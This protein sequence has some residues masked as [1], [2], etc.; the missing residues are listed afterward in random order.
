MST[1]FANDPDFSDISPK[2]RS[3]R[4]FRLIKPLFALGAFS[5][6]IALFL[7]AS[8]SSRPAGY[9][10]QC[11]NNLRQIALALLMYEQAYKS[12]PPA[13]TVD[14]RGRR[15]HS[16]RTLILPYLEKQ[17]LYQ[18]IDLAKPWNDPANAKAFETPLPIFRCPMARGPRNTTTYLA[19]VA[20][21]SCWWAREPQR[22][23]EITDDHGLTLTV[24][25]AGD[26]NAV[27]WMAPVDADESLMMSLGSTTKSHHAGG[28]NTAFVDA[29][30]R[31]LDAETSLTRR[32]ALISISGNDDAI[33]EKW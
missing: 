30:V 31:F 29:G 15:L 3:P 12:L 26:E 25:E 24:I 4:K 28:M 7:P 27:P 11:S 22:L 18:A 21:N 16:W 19:V 2:P 33:A 13:C 17:S 14:A 32:R 10:T 8:R 20:P 1:H 23:A 9:R 6:L 5:L